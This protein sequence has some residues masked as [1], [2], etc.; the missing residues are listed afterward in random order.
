[1]SRTHGLE[2]FV[3]THPPPRL[4]P[5]RAAIPGPVRPSPLWPAIST[6]FTP[7][8]SRQLGVQ[9]AEARPDVLSGP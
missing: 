4:R 3:P 8:V 9:A 7:Q 2:T 1:M 5:P 6:A